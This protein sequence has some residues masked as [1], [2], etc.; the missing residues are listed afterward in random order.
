M[1]CMLGN[2][3]LPGQ[4]K[5]VVLQLPSTMDS[6]GQNWDRT[7][8]WSEQTPRTADW[9]RDGMLTWVAVF[10]ADVKRGQ[11]ALSRPAHKFANS[12]PH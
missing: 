2:K 5:P 8:N 11:V 10:A 4:S 6:V 1:R 7:G 9:V 3:L 12:R